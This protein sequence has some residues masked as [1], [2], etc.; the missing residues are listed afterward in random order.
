[1]AVGT[2]VPVRCHRLPSFLAMPFPCGAVGRLTRTST[3]RYR[4][5]ARSTLTTREAMGV[6]GVAQRPRKTITLRYRLP[7]RVIITP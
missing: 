5:P 7:A 4:L 2:D 3:S 6:N 1:M